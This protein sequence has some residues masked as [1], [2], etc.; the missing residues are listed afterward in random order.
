MNRANALRSSVAPG[1]LL[2]V[3]AMG[4]ALAIGSTLPAEAARY[5]TESDTGYFTYQGGP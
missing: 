3:V 5:W 1:A 2:R 4:G